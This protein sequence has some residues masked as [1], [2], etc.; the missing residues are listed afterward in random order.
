MTR[1]TAIGNAKQN[2]AIRMSRSLGSTY[3]SAA[4]K[5][6]GVAAMKAAYRFSSE[7]DA[8]DAIGR[9]THSTASARRTQTQREADFRR[10]RSII[11]ARLSGQNGAP[12]RIR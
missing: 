7:N 12:G 3:I 2:A 5:I 9:T 1:L 10:A 6:A 4:A 11:A 8:V